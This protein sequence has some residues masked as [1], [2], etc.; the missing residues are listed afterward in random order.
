[1]ESAGISKHKIMDVLCILYGG[2]DQVGCTTRD[3]YNF[4]HRYKQEIVAGGDAQTVIRHIIARQER[5]PDYLFKYFDR[6]RHLKG[7]FWS[8]SQSRI[9]YEAFGDVVFDSTYRT[10]KYN[11]SF[12]L[13]VGLNHHRGTAIFGCGVISH[14]TNEAYEW[15]LHTF[16]EAMSQK[17]LISVITEG[18]L[19]MQRAIRVAWPDSNNRLC[20]W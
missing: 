7:L 17:H 6:D 5:N 12:V 2:Y 8:D 15:M 19:A 13:F 4:C 16:S 14:E 11:L 18:D 1:M 20:V 9:D 10:N 3:I